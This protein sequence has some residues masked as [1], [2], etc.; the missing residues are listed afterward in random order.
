[1]TPNHT[2]FSGGKGWGF[3]S[4]SEVSSHGS[5]GA[6]GNDEEGGVG[7]HTSDSWTPGGVLGQAFW[8]RELVLAQVEAGGIER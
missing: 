2:W 3:T 7:G 1:M 4:E 6:G 8:V 5:E